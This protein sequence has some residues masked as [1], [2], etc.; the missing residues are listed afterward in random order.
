MLMVFTNDEEVGY[1]NA[2]RFSSTN[3]TQYQQPTGLVN[4]SS[5]IHVNYHKY[6]R[7]CRTPK[8][9][10]GRSDSSARVAAGCNCG[11]RI[12]NHCH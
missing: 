7:L 9:H 8:G 1:S 11:H 5:I 3:I 2:H 6:K 12:N 4:G 10:G